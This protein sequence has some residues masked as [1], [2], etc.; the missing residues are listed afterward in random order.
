[1]TNVV[2]KVVGVVF[3]VLVFLY[4]VGVV[5]SVTPEG[6]IQLSKATRSIEEATE[7][8]PKEGESDRMAKEIVEG[9]SRPV[10]KGMESVEEVFTPSLPTTTK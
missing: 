10:V 3:I 6:Q 1:M 9:L 8:I 2:L 4:V 5:L 7:R